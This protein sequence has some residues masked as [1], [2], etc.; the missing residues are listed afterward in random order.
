[1]NEIIIRSKLHP[2]KLRVIGDHLAKVAQGTFAHFPKQSPV[3]GMIIGKRG[4]VRRILEISPLYG[5]KDEYGEVLLAVRRYTSFTDISIDLG[6]P[7]SLAFVFTDCVG[8]IEVNG[9]MEDMDRH[10]DSIVIYTDHLKILPLP[11]G[12]S[13]V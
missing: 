11:E 3:H 2:K 4:E 12:Y 5:D 7:L 13:N 6:V 8:L 10:E 1:M 9:I